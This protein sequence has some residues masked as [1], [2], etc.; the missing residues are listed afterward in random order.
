MQTPKPR[1]I[2]SHEPPTEYESPLDHKIFSVNKYQD[3]NNIFR[4]GQQ[5]VQGSRSYSGA[6]S[7]LADSAHPPGISEAM[8]K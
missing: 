4:V 5:A 6:S 7:P 8:V 2:F 3:I 1:L